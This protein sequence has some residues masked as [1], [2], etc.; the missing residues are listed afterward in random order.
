MEEK[1]NLP[2]EWILVHLE[3]RLGLT[4]WGLSYELCLRFLAGPTSIE[5][6]VIFLRESALRAVRCLQVQLSAYGNRIGKNL[7]ELALFLEDDRLKGRPS[8]Q[9]VVLQLALHGGRVLQRKN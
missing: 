8:F 2:S 3:V 6:F 4:P 7:T 5:R 9:A 1:H